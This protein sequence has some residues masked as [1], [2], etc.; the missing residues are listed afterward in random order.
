M[1]IKDYLRYS[2]PFLLYLVLFSPS[3]FSNSS[4][5]SFFAS[6]G[7][8]IV[9]I[10]LSIPQILLIF[11]FFHI[12]K[13]DFKDNFALSNYSSS[14]RIF[15]STLLIMIFTIL[16]IIIANSAALLLKITGFMQNVP[17]ITSSKQLIPLYLLVSIVTGYREELFFRAYLIKFFEKNTNKVT[18]TIAISAMFAICHISQGTAGIIVSFITSVLLCFIFFR[19]RSIHINGLSH[20]LYNFFVLLASVFAA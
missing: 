10:T 5:S 7:T 2:E 1:K 19:Y 13:W 9:Y 18:L 12:K 4:I 8:M 16:L 11:Y 6:T 20:A 17:A 15:K 3:V 14:S